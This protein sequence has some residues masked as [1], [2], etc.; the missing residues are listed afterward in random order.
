V[1]TPPSPS[2]SPSPSTFVLAS[3]ADLLLRFL[4]TGRK[5]SAVSRQPTPVTRHPSPVWPDIVAMAADHGLA[6]LLFRRLKA[7]DARI[8]VPA[9][10]WKWLRLAF[11]ANADRNVCLYRELGPVLR[12]LR[13]SGIPVIVL[14]GAYLAEAVYG[15][16]ALR[17][18]SDVDLMVPR[19][20]LPRAHTV[21]L[22]TGCVRQ[23]SDDIESRSERTAPRFS[24]GVTVEFHWTIDVPG[25]RSRLDLAGLW[26]RARPAMIAGVEV[27][28][29][30][31]L[32]LHLCLHASH[33]HGLGFGLRPFCDIAEMI[34][35]FRGEMDWAQVA[36]RAREWRAARYVGLTLHLARSMLDAEVPDEVLGQLAPGGIDQRMLETARQAVL[37]QIGYERLM[38]LFDRLG[39][40]SVGDKVKLSWERVFLS[41][42]EMAAIYPA[43]RVSKHL[44]FYRALRLRDVIRTLW[45]HALRRGVLMVRSRGRDRNDSL[46]KWLRSR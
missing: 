31:D 10:V 28:A 33:S 39:A 5:P 3:P 46:V 24:A 35:R 16:V 14:K 25:G 12:R 41:R 13:S 22:D 30:E 38:P 37:A 15:D 40:K 29:P 21:L 19:A 18:M 26:D 45:S 11:F 36:E 7:G 4:S 42:G 20:D 6:P 17:P 34:H 44:W 1:D 8:H 27:L 9:D 43:S 32:L 2:A 23:Q